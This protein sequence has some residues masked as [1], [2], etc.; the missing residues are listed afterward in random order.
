MSK[1]CKIIE[2]LLPL[3]HDG[4]CSPESRE[5]VEAH[6][7][8]CENCRKILSQID[9]ELVP[10]SEEVSDIDQLKSLAKKIMQKQKT[11]LIKGVAFTLAF[12]LFAFSYNCILWYFQEYRFY[13]PFTEGMTYMPTEPSL[14]ED[15]FYYRMDDTYDVSVAMPGFLSRSGYVSVR[16]TAEDGQ[17]ITGVDI[18]RAAGGKYVF[19]VSLLC[20]APDTYHL[21]VVDSDLHLVPRYYRNRSNKEQDQ[22]KLEQHREEV[23]ALMDLA[24][25]FWPFLS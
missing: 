3:Y 8:Q 19:H 9:I 22:E 1:E 15:R 13:K 23:Q 4:I 18:R 20:E 10:P 2:D 11:A 7:A 17:L 6:L 12:L 24:K 21:F 16:N 25:K 14:T 5:M